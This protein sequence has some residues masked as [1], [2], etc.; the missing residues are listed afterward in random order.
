MRAALKHSGLICVWPVFEELGAR[1]RVVN[2]ADSLVPS[3]SPASL[4]NRSL[5]SD[6]VRV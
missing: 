1:S 6:T 5:P 3:M 2:V 4:N